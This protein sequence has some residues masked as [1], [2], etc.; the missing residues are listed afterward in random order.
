M[1]AFL[2]KSD[3]DTMTQVTLLKQRSYGALTILSTYCTEAILFSTEH[4]RAL[5]FWNYT[6]VGGREKQM[7]SPVLGHI[8]RRTVPTVWHDC[9]GNVYLTIIVQIGHNQR[10]KLKITVPHWNSISRPFMK[11]LRN[12]MDSIIYMYLHFCISVTIKMNLKHG[13]RLQMNVENESY[14]WQAQ[15]FLC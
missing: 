8:G 12:E 7:L 3:C 14:M 11:M 4:I 9:S 15:W 1:K 5:L 6:T 10:D 2:L 13:W